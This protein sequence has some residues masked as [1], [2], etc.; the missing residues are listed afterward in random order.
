MS[1]GNSQQRDKLESDLLD[2]DLL[3]DRGQRL[4]DST[5]TPE[6][7]M[8]LEDFILEDEVSKIFQHF[9]SSCLTGDRS[10]T[11]IAIKLSVT[12]CYS[13]IRMT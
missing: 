11:F 8:W 6:R 7:E 10:V 13:L 2:N 1:T 9:A 12:E 4:S 5:V 3:L